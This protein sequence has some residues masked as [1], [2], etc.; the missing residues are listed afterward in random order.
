[1]APASEYTTSTAYLRKF[2]WPEIQLN[3]WLL[4]VLTSAATC[5]GIFS[6]F[7]V[8]QAQMEQASPWVFPFMI[9][10]SILALLFIVLIFVLSFQARLIPELIILGS[11]VLFVLWLAGLIGT[12]IQ[13]YG[14]IANVNSNCQ[15]YVEAIEFR[16][17][18]INT[19]AW[20]TQVNICN[21]WKAAFSLQLVNT[22]FFV[23]M[24]FMA[25]QVRRGER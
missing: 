5:L 11:F 15:N 8:V 12:S 1:M 19:L 14:S 3:I 6:W 2:H 18:S 23:W 25:L 21:C 13:L 9:A 17:A 22:V 10:A 20:L 7:M 4:V 16:G 24:L